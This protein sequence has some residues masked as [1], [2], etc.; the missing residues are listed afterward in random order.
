MSVLRSRTARERKSPRSRR[1]ALGRKKV[2][3]NTENPSTTKRTQAERQKFKHGR[4]ADSVSERRLAGK[5]SSW[6]PGSYAISAASKR[7]S[8]LLPALR[9]D[10]S[11]SR[12]FSLFV[13]PRPA[14]MHKYHWAGLSF[15][16]KEVTFLRRFIRVW[17]AYLY[18]EKRVVEGQD[19]TSI[20]KMEAASMYHHGVGCGAHRGTRYRSCHFG[21]P[22]PTGL[23]TFSQAPEEKLYSPGYPGSLPQQWFTECREVMHMICQEDNQ[24]RAE[25]HR[26]L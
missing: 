17:G 24:M 16:I 21:Y 3:C 20:W 25:Q 13:L 22:T 14:T 19:E 11:E 23:E 7:N 26:T 5:E 8:R 18:A 1:D 6:V 10:G 9:D 4:F 12:G 2:A 15:S